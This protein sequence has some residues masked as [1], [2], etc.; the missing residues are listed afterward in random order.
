[1]ATVQVTD[2]AFIPQNP[3]LVW[4]VLIDFDSYAQWW[5]R[6]VRIRVLKTTPELIGSQFEVRPFGRK[7]FVCEVESVD[8]GL[9]LQLQY[10]DGTYA[11]TGVWSIEPLEE[12]CRVSYAVDLEIVDRLTSALSHV[13]NLGAIHSRL[14]R[15]I[16]AGLGS[17]VRQR[18]GGGG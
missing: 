3:A 6:S 16:F 2:S 18:G 8:P 10:L 12:G 4:N 5:P 11:G 15:K 14:V 1:M 13:V 17:H 7:G 9:E